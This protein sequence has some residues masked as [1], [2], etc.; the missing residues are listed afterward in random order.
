MKVSVLWMLA[1]TAAS[2]VASQDVP[3]ADII[4]GVAQLK[5]LYQL[6]TNDAD[7]AAKTQRNFLNDGIG[8]AQARSLYFLATGD[9]EKALAIQKKFY[10][11][12]EELT[13]SIPVV[14]H[15]KG[16]VHLLTGDTEHG[17]TA[18]KSA[19]SSTG[20]AVGGAFG[21]PLGA[22]GGHTLTDL[23]ITGVDFAINGGSSRPYGL[24]QYVTHIDEQSAEDHFRAATGLVSNVFGGMIGKRGK[25]G[26]YNL[27]QKPSVDDVTGISWAPLKGAKKT[28]NLLRPERSLKPESRVGSWSSETNWSR[29]GF[30]DS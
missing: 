21:G 10:K 9:A 13:D 14:G 24:V 7:G 18:I 19:T 17:W 29:V 22:V 12:T 26:Y 28:E 16:A 25:T 27:Q 3:L 1:V 11:N 6:L 23:A 2:M 5:S 30:G 15:I 4:L 20:S 8:T